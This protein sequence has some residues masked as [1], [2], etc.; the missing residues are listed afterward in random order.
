VVALG[1]ELIRIRSGRDFGWLSAEQL[2][3][4]QPAK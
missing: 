4:E 1:K 2:S 3:E